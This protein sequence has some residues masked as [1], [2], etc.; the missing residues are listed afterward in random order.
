M[1]KHTNRAIKTPQRPPQRGR[2]TTLKPLE[3][4]KKAERA[5]NAGKHE[6][7]LARIYD[8]QGITYARHVKVIAG[9]KLEWDFLVP[10][11]PGRCLLVEVQ[12]NIWRKGGHNTGAGIMRDAEKANLATIHGYRTLFFTP[13]HIADGSALLWTLEA[14]GAL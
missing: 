12:G 7:E 6:A 8:E 1:S 10:D 3:E 11:D 14:L 9:R 5:A 2:N 4:W 13:E